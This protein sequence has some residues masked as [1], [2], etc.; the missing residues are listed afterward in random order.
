MPD[1]KILVVGTTSDYID[2]LRKAAPGKLLFVTAHGIRR[3]AI[4][5][6]PLPVEEI[7][8]DPSSPEIVAMQLRQHVRTFNLCLTGI[9]CFD[10]ESL[11][12]SARIAETFK[13]PFPSLQCI[14]D[15]H[16]KARTKEIWRKNNVPCP[17]SEQVDTHAQVIDFFKKANGPCVLKP[18]DSSGSERVFKC[19]TTEECVDAFDTIRAH[20]VSPFVLIEQFVDGKEYSC[21]FIVENGK[22]QLI[23]M[24]RKLHSKVNFFGTIMAYEIID[25]LSENISRDYFLTLLENATKA[26]GVTRAVCMLDFLVNGS[27]ISL[28]ELSPRP[29]GD[30]LPWLLKRSM[31]LDILKLTLDFAE[32]RPFVFKKPVFFNPHVGLRVHA[33]RPGRFKLMDTSSVSADPRVTDVFVKNRP[34]H[35]IKMPPADYDSWNLG[36]I[37]FKPY[38]LVSRDDQCRELL[39]L[40]K[41]E[42]EHEPSSHKQRPAG[43]GAGNPRQKNI[44]VAG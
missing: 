5:P 41:V 29:G 38:G 18:L 27:D 39:S 15:C 12:S 13:L 14:H 22:V 34:G 11:E 30:C 4:E 44:T 26:L 35:P 43:S 2:L 19:G 17:F 32:T 40:L 16:D 21:D 10:C 8:C 28:L 9:A 31:G 25:F 1:G 24:A 36:H 6:T 3:H 7:L 33:K 37:I 23:R 42:I 20:Q